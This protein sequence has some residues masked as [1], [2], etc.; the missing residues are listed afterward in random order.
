MDTLERALRYLGA[1]DAQVEEH[2]QMMQQIGQ[3]S[4]NIRLVPNRNNLLRIDWTKL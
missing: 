2:R 3:G 4:S 1:T